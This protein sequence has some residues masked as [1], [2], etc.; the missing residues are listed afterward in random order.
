[1]TPSLREDSSRNVTS[2]NLKIQRSVLL[3]SVQNQRRLLEEA[4]P[5]RS[6]MQAYSPLAYAADSLGLPFTEGSA[7]KRALLQLPEG[8][9]AQA[10]Y[11]AQPA[12]YGAY[13]PNQR[14]LQEVLPAGAIGDAT[15][16]TYSGP[17]YGPHPSG[18]QSFGAYKARPFAYGGF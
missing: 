1:M 15:A 4:A 11:V 8:T 10:A 3:L 17:V 6:L 5:G 13:A 14:R 2:F 12:S 9:L 7:R 18:P 16:V